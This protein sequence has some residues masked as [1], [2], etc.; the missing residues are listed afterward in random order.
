MQRLPRAKE[1]HRGEVGEFNEIQ[2]SKKKSPK[3]QVKEG[4]K[5]K[6]TAPK[7][8]MQVESLQVKL[9][10]WLFKFSILLFCGRTPEIGQ[11]ILLQASSH[12]SGMSWTQETATNF[13]V[14]L[15]WNPKDLCKSK[16]TAVVDSAKH[17]YPNKMQ[18][19]T[20]CRPS[21]AQWHLLCPPP[22]SW[23]I[24]CITLAIGRQALKACRAYAVKARPQVLQGY[25]KLR[26]LLH[27]HQVKEEQ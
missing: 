27:H 21:Q 18:T 5:N 8:N 20:K 17:P 9:K 14:R 10:G 11:Q 23:T 4:R 22:T 3:R 26:F 13:L 7:A 19:Q 1:K 25:S 6:K 2:L 16:P 24:K 12:Q 15:V